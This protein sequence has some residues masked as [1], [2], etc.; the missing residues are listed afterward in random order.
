MMNYIFC[1]LIWILTQLPVLAQTDTNSLKKNDSI[2]LIYFKAGA[3]EK[4]RAN[5]SP[6]C[7]IS[8]MGCDNKVM[9]EFNKYFYKEYNKTNDM[10]LSFNTAKSIIN[11]LYPDSEVLPVLN[12]LDPDK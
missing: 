5:V 10:K 9:M 1:T 3:N 8:F 2:N 7:I 12:C 11:S 6:K 4:T